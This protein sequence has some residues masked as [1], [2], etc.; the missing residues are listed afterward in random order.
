MP[1]NSCSCCDP[2]LEYG[3][4]CCRS[5]ALCSHATHFEHSPAVNLILQL[6][7][8]IQNSTPCYQAESSKQCQNYDNE[9]RLTDQHTSTSAA[10]HQ[11][12]LTT[13]LQSPLHVNRQ[14]Y[15]C[16]TGTSSLQQCQKCLQCRAHAE[17]LP[18]TNAFFTSRIF[19]NFGCWQYK[20]SH[21]SRYTT[22]WDSKLSC[23]LRRCQVQ[24]AHNTNT[25]QSLGRYIQ[26]LG[27][28][29]GHKELSHAAARWHVFSE[30]RPHSKH[31]SAHYTCLE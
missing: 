5:V 22:L 30:A 15:T 7:H 19:K 9:L 6:C 1:G 21:G 27:Q 16:L 24:S 23:P 18:S 11:V 26:M 20:S 4:L 31:G 25:K 17:P 12:Q 28:S 2:S 8:F 29:G 3:N 13:A 10:L 14:A